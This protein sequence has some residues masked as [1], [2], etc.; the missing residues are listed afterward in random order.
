LRDLAN[1]GEALLKSAGLFINQPFAM[2]L[3]LLS[4]LLLILALSHPARAQSVDKLASE[5]LAGYQQL[6]IPEL[7]F[8]YQE[9]LRQVPA[10]DQLKRQQAFFRA[11]Q[12]RLAAVKRTKLTLKEQI[13]YDHLAYET[14]HNLQR[15][16]LETAFRK[17]SAAVP[18]TGMAALPSHHTWYALYT[19]QYTSTSL[20]ADELFAFGQQQVQRVQGEIRRLRRQ[21]GYGQD[22]AGF[23]RYL[24][25]D[26]FFLTD[27]N[28]II[29]CYRGIERRIRQHLPVAFADTAVPYLRIRT[30]PG[31]TP[32]TPPGMYRNS[33]VSYDFNFS[34]G[35]HNTRAMEW[36]Y[37][38]EGIPGHHYQASLQ[39]KSPPYSP[40]S[41]ITFYSGNA[42]G[43]GCYVEYLGRQ[44]G[45]YQQ[46]ELEL[47]KWEWDL[48]RSARVVLD[49]GIHDRGWTRAQ[50]LAYWQANVPGQDDIAEREI[51]RV[52]NWPAQCLSYKVGAQ[53]I[54]EMKARLARRPGFS[55]RRFH[56]AYLALS[57][58]PLE[59]VERNIEA[60]YTS[61]NV[62]G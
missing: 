47:G 36:I 32:A 28:Q 58:L 1:Y 62:A 33:E 21:M 34:T 41:A 17:T 20:G 13:A 27:S 4:F 5:Y 55:L 40:L 14:A 57:G 8:D 25:S 15:L 29:Q 10:A 53:R 51:N 39:S 2:R 18:A 59:V 49:V 30:W 9:N 61:L 26:K 24:A 19:K 52:T 44:L 60:V 43:W 16:V 37:E 42:E 23:Y 45:L 3:P 7:G 31:A 46:P 6:N 12:R 48:V 11:M 50:A 38:H 56:A 35:R 22:S 54:E